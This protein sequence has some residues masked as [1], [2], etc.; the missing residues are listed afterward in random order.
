[1]DTIKN[2]LKQLSSA[3]TSTLAAM[4]L[5]VAS[6]TSLAQ[7]QNNEVLAEQF[8]DF[9]WNSTYELSYDDIDALYELIIFDI[10]NSDR[11]KLKSQGQIG[12]RLTSGNNS[13]T[14]LE[15]N[16]I[17]FSGIKESSLLMAVVKIRQSL[18]SVPTEVPLS[19]LNRQEQLAYW[20]NLHNVALI[21]KLAKNYPINKLDDEIEEGLL[22][23]KWL[24]VAGQSLSLNDIQQRIVYPIYNN[25]TNVIYGFYQGYI[26][27][28]SITSK[29]YTGKN[30]YKQL[31]NRAQEFINSNR[32]TV[33]KRNRL[34]VST[35]YDKNRV[36]FKDFEKDLLAHIELYAND[37]LGYKLDSVKRIEVD[38]EDYSLT[39]LAGSSRVVGSGVAN[40]QA[41]LLDAVVAN[42]NGLVTLSEGAGSGLG[43]TNLGSLS[44]KMQSHTASFGRFTPEQVAL[45]QKLKEQKDTA[46]GSVE[47]KDLE[48]N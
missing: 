44:Q 47:I 19:Q 2:R 16:R 36:F 32:G 45:L 35:Y 23:E 46:Q 9:K 12:T 48:N 18:E 40:N 30:V 13:S 34:E 29:A 5:S 14:A 22:D 4:F 37:S 1:M 7:E 38:I 41:G 42:S 33:V 10:G 24:S 28:P 43:A 21:E 31:E 6:L 39:D 20:L 15:A 11:S 27:S 17:H 25:K 26:S 3:A 8:Q